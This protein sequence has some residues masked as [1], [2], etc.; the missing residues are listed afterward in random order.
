MHLTDHLMPGIITMTDRAR[1]YAI[2]CWILWHIEHEENPKSQTEFLSAFQRREAAIALATIIGDPNASPVGK[3]AV[4]KQLAKAR[5]ENEVLLAFQV[6]PSNRLG[7]YGQYYA[8]CLYA[9]GLTHRPDG[10]FDRVTPGFAE[11]LARSVHATLATTP[12]VAKSLFTQ[13]RL[14][15][16]SLEQSSERLGL[17][18]IRK[19]YA[20]TERTLLINLLFGFNQKQPSFEAVR[21]CES[22]AR[23]LEI[24]DKYQEAG[25]AVVPDQLDLQ[26]LYGPTY[27]N[28]LISA[29]GNEEVESGVVTSFASCDEQWQQFC[30]Q[31]YLTQAIEILLA[32][33]LEVISRN[34]DGLTS[35]EILDVIVGGGEF[36]RH[37]AAIAGGRCRTPRQLLERLDIRSVPNEGACLKARKRYPFEHSLS[38]AALV[39]PEEGESA[40]HAA[41]RACVLLAVLYAKWRGVASDPAWRDVARISSS[42]LSGPTVLPRLDDWLD[43]RRDWTAALRAVFELIVSQHDRVMYG[44]GRLESRWLH[45]EDERYVKDQDHKPYFR[46]ARHLQATRIMEDLGLVQ[47]DAGGEFAITGRGREILNRMGRSRQ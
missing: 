29:D 30:L 27:F 19:P 38:E 4:E 24:L 8:G 33:V 43:E 47:R 2:Y 37:L 26:L 10:T 42:E 45:M 5:D 34:A 46:S 25:V 36:S 11:D 3:R 23:M 7:G 35:E 40:S 31:Q 39:S 14:P 1:Y 22:L 13:P 44:K 17:D 32:S 21:R 18:A 41:A 6:L 12:Y 16:K 9:L 28:S 15:L 20:A